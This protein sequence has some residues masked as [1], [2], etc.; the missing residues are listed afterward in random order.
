MQLNYARVRFENEILMEGNRRWKTF[1]NADQNDPE[2]I[3]RWNN[4]GDTIGYGR[5]SVSISLRLWNELKR[6]SSW[7]VSDSNRNSDAE[8]IVI[9]MH[10]YA[11]HRLFYE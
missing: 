5:S 10:A 8:S 4:V 7:F 2:W 9:G 3:N 11:D 1:V 6:K